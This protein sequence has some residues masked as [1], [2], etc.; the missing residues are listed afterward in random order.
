MI[1]FAIGAAVY[2]L[3]LI[4]VGLVIIRRLSDGC[5]DISQSELNDVLGGDV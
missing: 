5:V 2:V 3:I 1:T 4:P